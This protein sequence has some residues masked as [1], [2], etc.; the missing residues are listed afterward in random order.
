MIR[1]AKCGEP[2]R[3]GHEDERICE[4]CYKALLRSINWT[5]RGRSVV[6]R[7]VGSEKQ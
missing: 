1:C 2:F 3:A 7:L 4:R 6:R 5:D